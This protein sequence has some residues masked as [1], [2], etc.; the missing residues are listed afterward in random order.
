MQAQTLFRIGNAAVD[1][2]GGGFL[3]ILGLD[4]EG[5]NIAVVTIVLLA[6]LALIGL[7]P[8]VMSLRRPKR[9]WRPS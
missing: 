5:G 7:V 2:D 1:E 8:T 6:C 4:G 9:V 3:A